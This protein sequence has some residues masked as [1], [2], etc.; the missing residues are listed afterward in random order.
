MTDGALQ[1][2]SQAGL[3]P[4]LAQGELGGEAG[5]GPGARAQQHFLWTVKGLASSCSCGHIRGDHICWKVEREAGMEPP[6]HAEYL[7]SGGAVTWGKR[8]RGNSCPAGASVLWPRPCGGA[9][10]GDGSCSCSIFEAPRMASQPLGRD[11]AFCW[12]IIQ[13]ISHVTKFSPQVPCFL[14]AVYIPGR[15]SLEWPS[16]CHR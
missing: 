13:Q 5:S 1:L 4:V 12:L 9:H 3:L 6:S 11:R 2:L 8:S 15:A 10:P 16:P 7:R 14:K